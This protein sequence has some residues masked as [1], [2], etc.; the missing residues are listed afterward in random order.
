M[1]QLYQNVNST[2]KWNYEEIKMGSRSL[3]ICFPE[4][5]TVFF[6]LDKNVKYAKMKSI[7]FY[8]KKY[9]QMLFTG[10]KKKDY[11]LEV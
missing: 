1:F 11:I 10:E 3:L 6:F 7:A 4:H 8:L 2:T 9:N 5:S